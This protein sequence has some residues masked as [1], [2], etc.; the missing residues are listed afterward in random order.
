MTNSLQRLTMELSLFA[1][2]A[3]AGWA[4]VCAQGTLKVDASLEIVNAPLF[5]GEIVGIPDRLNV[6][7]VLT[8]RGEAETR[9]FKPIP[10]SRQFSAGVEAPDGR[11]FRT[12]GY[13][14]E[15]YETIVLSA[16]A[17]KSETFSLRDFG[18]AS[19]DLRQEGTY[20]IRVSYMPSPERRSVVSQV[21]QF[22]PKPLVDR[23]VLERVALPGVEQSGASEIRAT[24]LRVRVGQKNR[25]YDAALSDG[26]VTSLSLLASIPSHGGFLAAGGLGRDKLVNV[27]FCPNE[28]TLVVLR[29]DSRTGSIQ[30]RLEYEESPLV[31]PPNQ[32][33]P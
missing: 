16:G 21:L 2:F 24:I 10:G 3:L 4:P 22:T 23:D 8:N 29:I 5:L 17:K 11:G 28:R 19:L 14:I 25:L 30:Q 6:K 20:R 32:T 1:I 33:R 27:A 15:D 18:Y 7:L 13:G 26:E 31:H 9:I 12:Q